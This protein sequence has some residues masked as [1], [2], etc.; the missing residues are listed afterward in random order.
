M[1]I[2]INLFEY[3]KTN[4]FGPLLV[5]LFE[6]VAITAGLKYARN[7]KIGIGLIFYLIID[8][9]IFVFGIYI[10]RFSELGQT[11]IN[12]FIYKTNLL[13]SVIELFAYYCFFSTILKNKKIIQI[14]KFTIPVF[15]L[16]VI[17]FMITE[18]KF[19]SINYTY[20][21]NLISVLG[22][23]L[24]ILPCIVFY[25]HLLKTDSIL[26]LFDRPSFWITTGIFFFCLTSIPFYLID[27]YLSYNRYEFKKM[28]NLA[29][30][31]IPLSFNFIFLT[32]AFLCKKKLDI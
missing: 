24:L 25:G 12:R 18:L 4:Y 26:G 17:V 13:I 8:L 11:E 5:I 22:F 15:I 31:Y 16:L 19:W 29:F 28:L 9:L 32:R 10:M 6:A 7:D 21:S 23:I 1:D 30:F 2:G 27:R 14:L 20:T 3:F